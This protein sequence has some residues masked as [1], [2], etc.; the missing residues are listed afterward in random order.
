[1][2]VLV[3]VIRVI[4]GILFVFSGLV[5]ANDPAGLSYKMH[6]FF[7]A[8]HTTYFNSWALA[9]AVLMIA[10]EII[11]GMALLLGW[12]KKWTLW[13]LLALIV[14]FTFLTGYAWLSGKF[15]A[16][17]CFGDCIPIKAH[18]SFYKDVVLLVLIIVLVLLQKYI[19]PIFQNAKLTIGLMIATIIGSFGI[20]K[21]TLDH[22]PFKDCLSFKVGNNILTLKGKEKDSTI[23]TYFY[24]KDGKE[25]KVVPPNYP[26]WVLNEDTSYVID[27]SK[28]TNVVVNNSKATSNLGDII[29]DFNLNGTNYNDT[30]IPI[31]SQ[32]NLALFILTEIKE[33]GSYAWEKQFEK[34]LQKYTVST[35]VDSTGAA[36]SGGKSPLYIVTNKADAAR[37]FFKKYKVDPAHVLFCDEKPLLAAAR[38]RPAVMEIEKAVIKAKYNW[39]DIN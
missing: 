13:L 10:F 29:H 26:D 14:F 9:L 19:Q 11:A 37:L 38:S 4:V 8:W 33:N 2:K 1:M 23:T 3:N 5:K 12:Q 30:T 35:T 20:Q 15:K 7:E 21:Y 32:S 6:E 17:G 31:L 36:I 25:Y 22:L 39:R 27:E 24:Y 28:T 16:C 34:L 18:Q